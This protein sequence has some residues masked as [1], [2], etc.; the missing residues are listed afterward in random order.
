MET[1]NFILCGGEDLCHTYEGGG[2]SKA[3]KA[4]FNKWAIESLADPCLH[5][6]ESF[7]DIP[8]SSERRLFIRALCELNEGS[9]TLTWYVGIELRKEDILEASCYANLIRGMLALPLENLKGLRSSGS[10]AVSFQYPSGLPQ[11]Q[12]PFDDLVGKNLYGEYPRNLW[13]FCQKISLNDIDDWFDRLFLAVNVEIARPEYTNMVCEVRPR[14]VVSSSQTKKEEEFTT[15]SQG[16]TSTPWLSTAWAKEKLFWTLC[17]IVSA[18]GLYLV[19]DRFLKLSDS[20]AKLR[21]RDQIHQEELARLTS[22]HSAAIANKDHV[23]QELNEKLAAVSAPKDIAK[24]MRDLKKQISEVEQLLN[25]VNNSGLKL[26]ELRRRLC[27]LK[28][29]C[30]RTARSDAE[31]KQIESEAAKTVD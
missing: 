23:I 1:K 12:T 8:V 19:V 11:I 17:L 31:V 10:L 16:E 9:R 18:G 6:R 25:V 5:G 24:T 4:L 21:E 22:S 14:A 29:E 30:E 28:E 15:F 3:G 26:E 20:M 2:I 27:A 13:D 7:L